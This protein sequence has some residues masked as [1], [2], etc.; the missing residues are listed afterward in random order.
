[1][2]IG[3]S[4]S[5]MASLSVYI[6]NKK[7]KKERVKMKKKIL[8]SFALVASVIAIAMPIASAMENNNLSLRE[9]AEKLEAKAPKDLPKRTLP[10]NCA[11]K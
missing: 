7:E 6:L 2:R 3:P 4:Y 10:K 5:R 11:V 8:M 1:M 9:Q